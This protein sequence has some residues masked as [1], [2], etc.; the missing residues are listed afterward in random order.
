M[1]SGKRLLPAPHGQL[2]AI[3]QG[4]GR[5]RAAVVLHPHPLYGGTMHNPVA[6]AAAHGLDDAGYE[7]LRINFRGVGE[8][9]GRY[10]EGR[11]E[12]EDASLALDVLLSERTEKPGALLV[13][14]YSFGAATA[15]RLAH[16]DPRVTGVIAIATPVAMLDAAVLAPS[17][18]PRLF[19]HG[20]NDDL[21]PLAQLRERLGPEASDEIVVLPTDHFFGGETDSLR[22][23]I[24][25]WAARR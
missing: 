16:R 19:V 10:D 18:R 4:R 9:S 8:S 25:D 5:D 15:L 14:G 2:E 22:E 7:T 3:H 13:A 12:L 21:A 23:R 20:E 11:G 24:R 6:Y 17:D 1:I